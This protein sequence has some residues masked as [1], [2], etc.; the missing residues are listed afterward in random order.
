MFLA[1]KEHPLTATLLFILAWQRSA[2][3]WIPLAPS[4]AKTLRRAKILASD[5]V[6]LPLSDAVV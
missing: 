2:L 6:E 1:Y 3:R 4:N 5:L